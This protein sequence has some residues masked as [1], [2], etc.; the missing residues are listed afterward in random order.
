MSRRPGTQSRSERR[1]ADRRKMVLRIH[2]FGVAAA[3]GLLVLALAFA[4]PAA[5]ALSRGGQPQAR[6]AVPA[7]LST[8]NLYRTAAG[9]PA[10]RD[11]PAWD[12]GLERHLTY[13]QSTPSQFL[14]GRY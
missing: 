4:S 13:L 5:S 6:H 1:P 12:V 10:V 7:W 11:R 14:T 2:G 9:L 8:I 3:A